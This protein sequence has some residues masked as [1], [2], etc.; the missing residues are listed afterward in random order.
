MRASGGRRVRVR[1]KC[2]DRAETESGA[3]ERRHVGH[4]GDRAETESGDTAETESGD[5][6]ETRR[7]QSGDRG[8]RQRVE[9]Q[10]RQRA[11]T[12]LSHQRQ[13]LYDRG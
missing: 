10:R 1:V 5:S 6:G 9:T 11:E 12:R 13:E 3:K 4:G 7:R 8:C 2:R